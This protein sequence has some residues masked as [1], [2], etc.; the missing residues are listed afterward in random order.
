MIR[1]GERQTFVAAGSQPNNEDL[2]Y[3]AYEDVHQA[4]VQLVIWIKGEDHFC[5]EQSA[6]DDTAKDDV[7]P[8]NGCGRGSETLDGSADGHDLSGGG[9]DRSFCLQFVLMLK[10]DDYD[11][12]DRISIQDEIIRIPWH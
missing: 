8:C 10:Q 4:V 11:S 5:V 1:H 12:M 3:I 2:A 7:E 6:E 9:K